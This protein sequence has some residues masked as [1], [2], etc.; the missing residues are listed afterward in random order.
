MTLGQLLQ[1]FFADDKIVIVFVALI[2]DLGLG[3]LAAF[4]VGNFR[5]SYIADFL[6]NDVAF[7]VLPYFLLYAGALVAGQQ[8]IVIPGLDLG[9]IAG[10][11]Y[12]ILIASFV[13]SIFNSIRELQLAGAP[14][15]LET[16]LAGSENAAPPKD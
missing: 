7:K 11:A 5:L 14:Q 8:E 6:R 2:L 16:A 3:I 4:K 1:R 9:V 13:G 15:T 10:G 12:V